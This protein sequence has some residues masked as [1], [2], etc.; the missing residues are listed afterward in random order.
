MRL[1]SW[2]RAHKAKTLIRRGFIDTYVEAT[3][4]LNLSSQFRTYSRQPPITKVS[5]AYAGRRL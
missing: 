4:W 5:K 1:E 3:Y 2:K